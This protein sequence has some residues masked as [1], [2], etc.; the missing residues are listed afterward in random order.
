MC[1]YAVGACGHRYAVEMADAPEPLIQS[2]NSTH[3]WTFERALNTNDDLDVSDLSSTATAVIQEA[4]SEGKDNE[5]SSTQGSNDGAGS[6]AAGA[7]NSSQVAKSSAAI[8]SMASTYAEAVRNQDRDARDVHTLL[9]GDFQAPSQQGEKKKGKK[10]KKKE[11]ARFEVI[12]LE[13]EKPMGLTIAEE[14]REMTEAEGKIKAEKEEEAKM[15]EE[16]EK[17]LAHMAKEIEETAEQTP[18]KGKP[19]ADEPSNRCQTLSAAVVHTV[20]AGSRAEGLVEVGDRLITVN[21]E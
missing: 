18:S 4:A 1:E 6:P 12:S 16:V 20:A 15:D 10:E 7:K 3:T 17:Y 19:T 13:V 2:R 21:G 5:S 8:E 14:I 11:K 9:H